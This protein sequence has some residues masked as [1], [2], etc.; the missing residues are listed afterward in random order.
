MRG[1]LRDLAVFL[2]L[3]ALVLAGLQGFYSRQVLT[4]HYLAAWRDKQARLAASPPPRLLLVGGSSLAFGVDSARLER[5]FGRSVVNLGLHAG[6]GA[7]FILRQ[8]EAAA[9]AGDLVLLTVEGP[10]LVPDYQGHAPTLLEL[11]TLAPEAIRYVPPRALP[12]LLDQGL[13][14]VG[15]RPRALALWAAGQDVGASDIYARSAFDERGDAVGHLDRGSLNGGGA[16]GGL[17]PVPLESQRRMLARLN[18]FGERVGCHGARAAFALAPVPEDDRPR[19]EKRLQAFVALLRR[20]LQMP[21][22]DVPLFY[23]RGE[24]FDTAFHLTAHGRRLRT[25]AMV[26]ALER[27]GLLQ[28]VDGGR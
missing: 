9:R 12:G 4:D 26:A 25:Q 6:L 14:L 3:Q 18:L 8:G 20:D 11:L 5:A 2:G 21:L 19:Q 27:A 17:P 23:P 13:Q 22:L 28:P 10:L 15:K 7:E 24:F 16:H 1:F